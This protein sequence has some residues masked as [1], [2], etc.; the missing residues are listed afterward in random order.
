MP[1]VQTAAGRCSRERG[2]SVSLELRV[3]GQNALDRYAAVPMTVKVATM[4]TPVPVPGGLTG[5][6]LHEE[7]LR[8]PYLKDYD[9]DGGPLTWPGRFDLS[10]WQILVAIVEGAV[11][12]GAA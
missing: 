2:A 3:I 1:S 8:D 6:A 12:G 7:P 9:A 10:S 11:V 5:I 4:L